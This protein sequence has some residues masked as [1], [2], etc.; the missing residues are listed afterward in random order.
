MR[1]TRPDYP[2]EYDEPDA[3]EWE[4]PRLSDLVKIFGIAPAADCLRSIDKHG[5][6]CATV[7]VRL[8]NGERFY[9]PDDLQKIRDLPADEP[10]EA[11]IVHGIAWDGSD[12]EWSEEVR[13]SRELTAALTRFAHA[14]EEHQEGSR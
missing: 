12:W 9:V 7:S 2:P 10:V 13:D 5:E 3:S 4:G 1:D 14:L 11:W 6:E 8:P